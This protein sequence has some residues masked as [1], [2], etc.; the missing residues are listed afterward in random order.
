M[1]IFSG[2]PVWG[3]SE[4]SGP[5]FVPFL[6]RWEN[7]NYPW[8]ANSRKF[9]LLQF[10]WFNLYLDPFFKEILNLKMEI[11]DPAC[12]ICNTQNNDWDTRRGSDHIHQ[13]GWFNLYPDLF[14]EENLNLQGGIW[15]SHCSSQY[16]WIGDGYQGEGKVNFSDQDGSTCIQTHFLKRFWIWRGNHHSWPPA[17]DTVKTVQS[18]QERVRWPP[19]NRM[20]YI[21]SGPILWGEP[22]YKEALYIRPVAI[23]MAV[24]IF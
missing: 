6:I 10:G 11:S 16:G 7:T 12:S 9:D 21:S 4:S 15:N 23:A 18:V 5:M 13:L 24:S 17:L 19:S 2:A 1:H 3:D 20:I 22:R 8:K 14:F